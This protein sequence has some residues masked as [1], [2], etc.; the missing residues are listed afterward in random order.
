MVGN[1]S[2][3]LLEAP[4]FALPVVNIGN[5]Q[6]GRLRAGN[7]IDVP[8]FDASDIIAAIRQATSPEFKAKAAGDEH[9]FGDGH[10]S[11]KLLSLITNTPLD[12]RLLGK[13]FHDLKQP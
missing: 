11:E 3:G 1:S 6:K 5:R 2:S 13:T 12:E 7:V 9:F 4:S 8:Q 10:A